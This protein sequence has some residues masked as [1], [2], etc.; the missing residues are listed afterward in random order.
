MGNTFAWAF[1]YSLIHF[2]Q[3]A[4]SDTALSV[5]ALFSVF[6]EAVLLVAAAGFF[7]WGYD[8]EL[9]RS[10]ALSALAVTVWGPM[11]KN[12][13]M[14]LRP[15][16]TDEGIA[17]L[18]VTDRS[19]DLYDVSAQSYAFPSGHSASSAALYGSLARGWKKPGRLK[20]IFT[21]L[22]GV[23]PLLVGCS[24]VA[25]GAH[26]PTDVAAGW[27]LGAIAVFGIPL[28]Q[29]A[30]KNPAVLAGILIFTA[31]PGFF[32]CS[33]NDYYTGFG[34]LTGSLLGML[35]EMRFV[36]FEPAA[37]LL[38]CFLRLAGG[39]ALYPLLSVLLKLP[40][41]AEFLAEAAFWPRFIRAARYALI[42]FL[43]MGVY[44]LLFRFEARLPRRTA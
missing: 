40:F 34:M 16:F 25:V 41:S 5:I 19:A 39:A 37:N 27:L 9:G 44:P 18:R 14:R 17:A 43:E 13:V 31:L 4:L 20:R 24:R 23:L 30:I 11:I 28:L 21:V 10:L 42:L 6:G 7:Y 8:K 36:R 38:L 3:S 12:A 33:S 29:R 22:A 2:L 26:Y 32:Y 35:F 15:Y 1:E